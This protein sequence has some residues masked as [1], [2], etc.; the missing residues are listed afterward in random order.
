MLKNFWGTS[1]NAVKIQIHIA[2]ITYCL[3]VIIK[4]DLKLNMSIIEL[5]RIVGNS[6]FVDD[7]IMELLTPI[8]RQKALNDMQLEFNFK[9]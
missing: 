6:S 9:F 5:M 7:P 1:E 8:K 2:I 4:N 3:I